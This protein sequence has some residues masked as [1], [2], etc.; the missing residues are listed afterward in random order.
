MRYF[1]FKIS[2]DFNRRKSFILVIITIYIH[3]YLVKNEKICI[4]P[5]GLNECIAHNSDLIILNY[6]AQSI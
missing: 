4:I 3:D 5:T 2:I 1:V 6:E